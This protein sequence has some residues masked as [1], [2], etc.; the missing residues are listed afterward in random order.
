M[1]WYLDENNE[2]MNA[3]L[4]EPLDGIFFPPYPANMWYM[5]ENNIVTNALLPDGL[6]MGAFIDNPNLTEIII[7]ESVK[8]IGPF[9]CSGTGLTEVTLAD[10]C[11]YYSTSFPEG[12]VVTGGHLIQ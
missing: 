10:D 7:P 11:D 5:D 1:S 4:P 8:S 9:A 12:C 3:D 2:L 6:Q